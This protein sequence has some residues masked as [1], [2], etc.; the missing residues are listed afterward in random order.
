MCMV[1][2]IYIKLKTFN[3]HYDFTVGVRVTLLIINYNANGHVLV[4]FQL[5]FHW[6]IWPKSRKK[7]YTYI[8]IYCL[9]VFIV[10]HM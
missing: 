4:L 8:N 1:G 6:Y 10:K 7:K 2:L 5:L 3:V 9:H